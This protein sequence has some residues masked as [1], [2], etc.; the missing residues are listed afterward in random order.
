MRTRLG[1]SLIVRT[2]CYTYTHDTTPHIFLA[3]AP[4]VLLRVGCPKCDPGRPCPSW[5]P[6]SW[7]GRRAMGDRAK[8]RGS[9]LLGRSWDSW[10]QMGRLGWSMLVDGT[11]LC[12]GCHFATPVCTFLWVLPSGWDARPKTP[13]PRR[14]QCW[15]CGR[16]PCGIA[17]D[18]VDGPVA[19][20]RNVGGTKIA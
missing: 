1:D 4:L 19:V 20:V 17:R 3:M 5:L 15:A 9:V 10:V 13:P 16:H 2:T 18:K 14:S 8:W 12:S 11:C 7:G 6:R